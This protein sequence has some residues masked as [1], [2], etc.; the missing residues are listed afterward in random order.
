MVFVDFVSP[1]GQLLLLLP[2]L[3]SHFPTPKRRMCR[4]LMRY[5]HL[6]RLKPTPWQV[7]KDLTASDLRWAY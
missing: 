6:L 5:K 4:K 7:W 1:L 2:L 3:L